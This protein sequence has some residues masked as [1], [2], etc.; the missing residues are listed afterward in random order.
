[1]GDI[2]GDVVLL[3][4]LEQVG[5]HV[6]VVVGVADSVHVG[7]MVRVVVHE[8]VEEGVQVSEEEYVGDEVGE[9]DNVE[10]TD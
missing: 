4:D 8:P 3:S 1:M 10:V 2:L 7:E 9:I 5:E 6:V